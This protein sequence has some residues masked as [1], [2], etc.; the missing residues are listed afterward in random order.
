MWCSARPI[1]EDAAAAAALP[2]AVFLIPGY[3]AQGGG[4]DA[5]VLTFVN[6]GHGPEGG[7]VSSSRGLLFPDGADTG[8]AADWEAAIDGA[9]THAID[10]LGGALARRLGRRGRLQLINQA[11]DH[12]NPLVQNAGSL[13]SRPNGASNSRCR[14]VPPALSRS[15]YFSTNPAG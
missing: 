4:A 1:P 15:T 2:D 11:F 3:G 5:A 13:A 8:A 7:V 14:K 12:L 9:L 10:D 6:R